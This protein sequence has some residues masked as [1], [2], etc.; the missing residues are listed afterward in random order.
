MSSIRIF[1]RSIAAALTLA[2]AAVPTVALAEG[3]P[4][5]TEGK[6]A[7]HGKHKREG[8]KEQMQFPVSAQK[9]QEMVEKR[10]TRSRERVNHMME[11]RNVPEATRA[12]IRKDLDAGA[13]AVREAAKRVGADGVVTKE[14]AQQVRQLTKEMKKKAKEKLG[15]IVKDKTAGQA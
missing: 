7:E 14:E 3:R 1:A 12:Q 13:S 2:V 5:P 8:R 15:P 11:K 6:R 4:A 10:L 9:F